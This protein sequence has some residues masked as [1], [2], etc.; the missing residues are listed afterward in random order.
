MA[1]KVKSGPC[2]PS[3]SKIGYCNVES[4][5]TVDE[6]GQ[7]VLPKEIRDKAGIKAGEKLTIISWKKDEKIYCISLIKADEFA[8]LVKDLLGPMF[9]EIINKEGNK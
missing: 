5:I 8:D 3:I 4:V 9:K 7:M 6:R 2:C 1:K